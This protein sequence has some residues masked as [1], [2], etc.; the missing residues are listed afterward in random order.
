MK[1]AEKL[2]ECTKNGQVY[3]SFEYFPP[4]TE[5]VSKRERERRERERERATADRRR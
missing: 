4:K 3:F 2:E 1:I 5:E